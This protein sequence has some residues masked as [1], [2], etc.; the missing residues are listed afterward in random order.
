[1]FAGQNVEFRAGYLAT[2]TIIAA[3]FPARAHPFPVSHVIFNL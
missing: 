1:M 2:R 3:G